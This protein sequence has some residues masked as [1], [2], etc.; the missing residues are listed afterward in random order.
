MSD[1]DALV[2]LDFEVGGGLGRM[3][4]RIIG[5]VGHHY[6]VQKAG[7]DYMELLDLDDLR[8]AKFRRAG[9]TAV[10]GDAATASADLVVAEPSPRAK[11]ES[12]PAQPPAPR[13]R[14]SDQLKKHLLSR[15]EPES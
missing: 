13:R 11:A 8:S 3:T 12:V 6:L 1:S 9:E 7:S 5:K 10:S 14:L 15:S 4:G 2:G